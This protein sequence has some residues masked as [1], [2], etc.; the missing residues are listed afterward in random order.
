GQPDSGGIWRRRR[1]SPVVST[2]GERASVGNPDA[3]TR[4]RTGAVVTPP[5]STE[6]RVREPDR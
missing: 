3:M 5:R 4:H 2:R 6:R 1:T